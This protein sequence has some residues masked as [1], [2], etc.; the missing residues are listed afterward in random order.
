MLSGNFFQALEQKLTLF[1]RKTL[2]E[3]VTSRATLKVVSHYDHQCT[4]QVNL[5]EGLEKEQQKIGGKY[6]HK[7]K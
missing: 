5:M 2:K 4:R 7:S 6:A 1:N 3:F